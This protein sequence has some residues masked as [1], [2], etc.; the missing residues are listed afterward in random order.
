M[1]AVWRSNALTD[2][3][4]TGP[5]LDTP[6]ADLASR[7]GSN[8]GSLGL[9]RNLPFHTTDDLLRAFHFLRC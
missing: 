5:A 6:V 1:R 7:V 8:S 9:A 3:P 2:G 4:D